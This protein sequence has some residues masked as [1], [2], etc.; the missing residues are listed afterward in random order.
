MK[1]HKIRLIMFH[2]LGASLT[3]EGWATHICSS[4][5][6]LVQIMAYRLFSA[7]PSWEPKLAYFIWISA[8][9]FQGN[10]HQNRTM[11]IQE[12]Y[13]G[14]VICKMA[15]ILS[16]P[17]C[18]NIINT[19]NLHIHA[20]SKQGRTKGWNTLVTLTL[21]LTHLSMTSCMFCAITVSS[22]SI[23]NIPSPVAAPRPTSMKKKHRMW[24]QRR[25]SASCGGQ[26]TW[27]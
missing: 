20:A 23:H 21:T 1:I 19:Q 7:K 2:C 4:R 5:L 11:F 24:P 15:T 22:T 27:L 13:F 25:I 17:Q 8:S 14:N 3:H 10:F 12:N 6:S 26:M 16:W 9:I 18:V